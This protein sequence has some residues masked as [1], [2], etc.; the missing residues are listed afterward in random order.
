MYKMKRQR[1]GD[2]TGLSKK[3]KQREAHLP[4]CNDPEC[5]RVIQR[6]LRHQAMQ[7]RHQVNIY[8]METERCKAEREKQ[9]RDMQQQHILILRGMKDYILGE[10]TTRGGRLMFARQLFN[11]LV[12]Y[13]NGQPSVHPMPVS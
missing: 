13:L 10:E 6:E 5:L 8:R 12:R 4:R 1:D 11:N 7:F 2:G 3:Q 9:H